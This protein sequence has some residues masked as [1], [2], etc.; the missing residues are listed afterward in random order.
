MSSYENQPIKR[1]EILA[2]LEDLDLTWQNLENV[3]EDRNLDMIV[4]ADVLD[5]MQ[6]EPMIC[7][8]FL[9]YL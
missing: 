3:F 1:K 7:S 8:I 2:R 6:G 5:S 9:L 4:V